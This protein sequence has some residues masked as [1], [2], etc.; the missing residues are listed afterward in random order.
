[1]NRSSLLL[2][3]GSAITDALSTISFGGEDVA[4]IRLAM[5]IPVAVVHL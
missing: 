3:H 1:M 5:D 2:F 4:Y